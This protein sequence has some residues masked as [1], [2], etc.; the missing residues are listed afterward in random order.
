[1]KNQKSNK[2][3]H[4][5]QSTL[6]LIILRI[7][8]IAHPE[9]IIIFGSAAR[10]SMGP[11]SDLDLL[12]IKSGDYHRGHLTEEIHMHLWGVKA[13]VDLILVKPEDIEQY[14][15][16]PALIIAPALEEGRIVYAA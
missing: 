11:H 10:G 8:E 7:V 14:R 4:F 9:K 2:S 1:M 13:S 16:S 3:L 5:E 15:N 12:V 6:D